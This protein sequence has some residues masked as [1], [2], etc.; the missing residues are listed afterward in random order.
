MSDQ[1]PLM[2]S[3]S[4]MRGLVGR[5]ITPTVVANYAATFGG[6]LRQ[7]T[8]KD[9]PHVVLGRDSRPSGLMFEMAAASGLIASGCR[10]TRVGVLSTP[11]VAIMIG[12]HNA[13]GGMVITASHNPIIWNGVKAL[14]HDGVAPPVDQA[15]QIIQRYKDDNP[16]YVPVEQI[17]ACEEDHSGVK[18]HLDSILPYID[19]QAVRSAKL[20]AVVDS[21]NGAGGEE[22][23]ALLEAL[24]VELVHMYAE[25]TGIF[26]HTPEP[27]KDNLTELCA[28]VTE[29]G[30]AIGFA[31]DPD[32][33]RLAVVDE[34][35]TY[36]GEEYTLALSAMH[37]L[38]NGDTSAANLSTSRMIDDIADKVG[39]KVMRTAVGEANV[40]A[41][42]RSCGAVIGGEGNGGVIWTKVSGV[43]DSLV[44]MALLLEMLAKRG[45]TLSELVAEIPAYAIVKDK[46]DATQELI[47][48]IN[49][50]LS[51]AFQG[52][53]M[54][55]QDGVRI[56]WPDRWVH[57]RPSNTEPIIRLIAEASS[58]DQ[59]AALISEVRLALGLA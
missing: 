50:I 6:W 15:M 26:P 25:P 13:E 45:K 27:T 23:K 21:V 53:K 39:A 36:I 55:T 31:Q 16:D 57:V 1:A 5:S 42:M 12:H 19:V 34:K 46:V 43:R 41:G 59:A 56:D 11:G 24:G 30:A 10:V 44:G 20:K 38:G 17:Q 18:V 52:E 14:R 2:L 32:A 35:G 7:S 49:P 58:E 22:A 4:G 3:V 9:A 40:A 37:L 51:E 29:H 33:D 47:N 8:K 48:Q 28:R 54:D